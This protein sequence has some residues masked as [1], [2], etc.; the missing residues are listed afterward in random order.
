MR[1]FGAVSQRRPHAG[2]GLGPLLPGDPAHPGAG[3]RSLSHTAQRAGGDSICPH[4]SKALWQ[5]PARLCL[6]TGSTAA[7]RQEP[8]QC[9]Q[10]DT[11]PFACRHTQQQQSFRRGTPATAR[12]WT[13]ATWAAR[14][15][16]SRLPAL[17][18]CRACVPIRMVCR[19]GPWRCCTTR[20]GRCAQLLQ[21]KA[22]VQGWPF[23]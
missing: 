11:T 15:M 2:P 8:P 10:A 18:A 17:C 20:A 6:P 14:C 3:P 19:S 16:I 5:L 21:C 7:Y 4:A 23:K 1:P 13:C 22:A 9:M 12:S